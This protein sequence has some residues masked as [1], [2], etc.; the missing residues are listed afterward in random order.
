[1]SLTSL[2]LLSAVLYLLSLGCLTYLF[3]RVSAEGLRMQAETARLVDSD[4][5][6][7]SYISRVRDWLADPQGLSAENRELLEPLFKEAERAYAEAHEHTVRMGTGHPFLTGMRIVIDG[8]GESQG[9][10]QSQDKLK[11]A[12][13][14]LLAGVQ[15]VQDRQERPEVEC[16][17]LCASASG[18]TH[19]RGKRK[20]F[21]ACNALCE[22]EGFTSSSCL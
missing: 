19:Q 21:R 12:Y 18:H 20:G 13:S 22:A 11:K 8:R 16:Y 9:L 5:K 17:C 3:V 4:A 6:R 15:E 7:E 10:N 1:M 14:A 2:K